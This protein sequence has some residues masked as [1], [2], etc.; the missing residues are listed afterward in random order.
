MLA[1]EGVHPKVMQQLAGHA[2]SKTTMDIYTHVNMAVKRAA[3]DVTED[4]FSRQGAEEKAAKR[5]AT[6]LA[7]KRGADNIIVFGDF[8]RRKR[9]STTPVQTPG[10][11]EPDSN[12]PDC[13]EPFTPPN[14]QVDQQVS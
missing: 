12:H 1:E 4:V 5:A 2:S 10:R 11:I 8:Q 6:D 7:A 9:G 14:T 13:H 3:A